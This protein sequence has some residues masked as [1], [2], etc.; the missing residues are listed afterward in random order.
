M[1]RLLLLSSIVLVAACAETSSSEGDVVGDDPELKSGEASLVV[2]LIDEKKKLLSR[3]NEQAKAKGLK[4]IPDTFE[5]KTQA[6][7]QKIA[8]LRTYFD[9][10]IMPAVNA[11]DQA[12][13]AWGPDSFTVW[14]KRSK[15]PGLCYRGNPSKVV[16]LITKGADT[17]FSDQIMI[18]GWRYKKAKHFGDGDEEYEDGFPDVWAEWRGDGTAV[19]VVASIGDGGD[20]L[21]PAIIPRCK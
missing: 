8:D 6:D 17:V 21:S 3:F 16:D 10:T 11:K 1:R 4:E 20:D 19:L 5:M 18:H 2:P 7:A 13:P 12:M 15:T 14:S 9:D